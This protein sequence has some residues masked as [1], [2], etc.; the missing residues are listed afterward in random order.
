MALTKPTTTTAT[1]TVAE[2]QLTE[3]GVTTIAAAEQAPEPAASESREVATSRGGAVAESKASD[4][5]NA[6]RQFESQMAD[7]GFEGMTL[8]GMSFERI[9]LPGEGQF[10]I[11]QDDEEL[12]KDFD[13]VVQGTKA[14]YVVRQS[15]DQDAEMYYSY[16]ADGRSNTEG[17]DQADKLQEW[18]EEGYDQPVIKKYLEVMAILVNAGERTGM[19]VMLS[20]PPASVQKFSGFVAQQQFMKKQMPNEF[21]TRCEVGK[22]VKRDGG[23]SFFPWAFK[24]AG[25]A[26]EDLF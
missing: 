24:N 1:Q 26:P 10:L 4:R 20:I 17:V 6:S 13:C 15:D 22:K 14:L 21:I 9:R 8:G 12:G 16:D 25:P 11:G 2:E 19:M 23:S 3:E 7:A 18:A 5:V